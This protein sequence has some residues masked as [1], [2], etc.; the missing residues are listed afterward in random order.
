MSSNFVK[1]DTSSSL[2]GERRRVLEGADTP[3]QKAHEAVRPSCAIT[4]DTPE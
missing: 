1:T 3:W 2:R 4:G